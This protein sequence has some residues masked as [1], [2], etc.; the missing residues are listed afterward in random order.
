M[1]S[2]PELGLDAL[3]RARR[4]RGAGDDDAHAAAAG[5]LAVP[6]GGGVEDHVDDRRRAAHQRHAVALDPAQDLGAVDLA[7]HDVLAAHPRDGVQHPPA[8]AVEL[9]QRVQVDVAVADAHV[10][11]ERRGVE[12]DVAVGELHAL[13]PGRRARR[14]VDRRR[15]VLVARPRLRARRRSAAAPRRRPVPITQP[16]LALHARPAPRRARGRRAAGGPRS[17]RRCS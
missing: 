1:N 10:P 15:G 13:G 2:Q 6:L 7:Q 8:V 9:R 12:P 11:A 14:V 3:D 5:D 16:P 4:R 17:A